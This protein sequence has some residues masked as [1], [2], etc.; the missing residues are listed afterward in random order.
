MVITYIFYKVIFNQTNV[1]NKCVNHFL[2]NTCE[3]MKKNNYILIMSIAQLC[4]RQKQEIHDSLFQ[5]KRFCT[6][7]CA[8]DV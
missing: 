5:T 8:A 4:R 6:H 7:D 2:S 1:S 3:I